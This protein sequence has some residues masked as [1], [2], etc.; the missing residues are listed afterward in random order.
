MNFTHIIIY[1]HI[2][3]NNNDKNFRT[4]YH[5]TKLIIR[6]RYSNL[7]KLTNKNQSNKTIKKAIKNNNPK[8]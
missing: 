5:P 3:N 8:T 6:Y 4:I 7:I 2:Y 1:K